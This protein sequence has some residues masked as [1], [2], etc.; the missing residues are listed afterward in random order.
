M[1]FFLTQKKITKRKEKTD[2]KFGTRI[3]LAQG[4]GEAW[5]ERG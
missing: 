3:P 5:T 2:K 4:T 1:K